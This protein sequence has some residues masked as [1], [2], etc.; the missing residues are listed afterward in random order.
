MI[1]NQNHFFQCS[2]PSLG[3]LKNALYYTSMQKNLSHQLVIFIMSEK[4]RKEKVVLH[5]YDLQNQYYHIFPLYPYLFLAQ[6]SALSVLKKLYQGRVNILKIDS[7]L[8]DEGVQGVEHL[9][10]PVQKTITHVY[11]LLYQYSKSNEIF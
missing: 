8:L 9:A 5:S 4:G 10:F 11:I 6:K 3:C 7:L 2:L 1:Q